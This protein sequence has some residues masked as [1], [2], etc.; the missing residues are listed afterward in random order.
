V[1]SDDSQGHTQSATQGET[2]KFQQQ[3]KDLVEHIRTAYYRVV[4]AFSGGVDSAVVAAAAYRALG[5][6]ALA[7]TG[8]GAAVPES[9]LA[10]AAS[11]AKAIGIE[12]VVVPTTEI[13][14]PDYVANR[15]DRCFHCK[16]T[17]YQTIASWAQEHQFETIL[18]GTNAEDLGDYR[19]GLKAAANWNVQA[20]LAELGY[21]KEVVRGIASYWGLSVASKPA[22]PCLASRIAYGQLVTLGRLDRI[23]SMEKW[24][25]MQGFHD[26]RA[27][28]H[29]DEL[30]RL[31][32]HSDELADAVAEPM[33]AKIATKATE[34]GFRYVTIDIQ[35]RQSGSMNR[36]LKDAKQS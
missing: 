28:I 16:S 27:R 8:L 21:G 34:L 5:S 14:N 6:N 35:G 15:S 12:H 29:A 30:L 9:D 26:V 4:I 19:P 25:S 23:E 17:L 18:S 22:S 10:A 31:E 20:P 2:L 1:T 11:V 13:Q 7:W 33:R 36:G 32:I 3:A 24:L